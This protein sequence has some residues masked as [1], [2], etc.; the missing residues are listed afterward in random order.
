M[1]P[2]K[3]SSSRKSTGGKAPRINL[4]KPGPQPLVLRLRIPA[5][6]KSTEGNVPSSPAVEVSTSLA[7][8][9]SEVCIVHSH[10]SYVVSLLARI[11]ATCA[12][13][14]AIALHVIG[15]RG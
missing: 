10:L 13:M 11:G 2:R 5:R 3:H 7:K 1:A 15:A 14:V 12:S 6:V 4:S 9:E 8:R